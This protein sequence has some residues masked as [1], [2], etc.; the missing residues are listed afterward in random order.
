MKT[1][2]LSGSTSGIFTG[3]IIVLS[4]VLFVF[5]R[6][7]NYAGTKASKYSMRAANSSSAAKPTWKFLPPALKVTP[8]YHGV[9][10]SKHALITT[11]NGT[12]TVFK[13]FGE[14]RGDECYVRRFGDSKAPKFRCRLVGTN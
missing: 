2:L 1:A 10:R 4:L 14:V 6:R 3:F 9:L 5:W 13:I 7:R 11:G 12:T 8:V